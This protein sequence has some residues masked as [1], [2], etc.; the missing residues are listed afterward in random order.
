MA[1]RPIQVGDLVVIVKTPPCGCTNGLGKIYRVLGIDKGPGNNWCAYCEKFF[2]S[3]IS[4]IFSENSGAAL[5]RLKRIPP[6][7]ELEGEKCDE[8]IHA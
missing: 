7:S 2:G 8:E 6:L 4:A 1:D 5:Y 3:H